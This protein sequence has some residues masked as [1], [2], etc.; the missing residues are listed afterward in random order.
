[1]GREIIKRYG[2]PDE[3]GLQ[4]LGSSGKDVA[5]ATAKFVC[6]TLVASRGG[7]VAAL[8]AAELC[9]QGAGFLYGQFPYPSG[10]QGFLGFTPQRPAPP[11]R[12]EPT[13]PVSQPPSP[14]P[15]RQEPLPPVSQPPSPPT[16]Q[17][18]S[19]PT[20]QPPSP[21]PSSQGFVPPPPRQLYGR[22]DRDQGSFFADSFEGALRFAAF[23]ASG[24]GGN[25]GFVEG[26]NPAGGSGGTFKLPGGLPNPTEITDDILKAVL[27]NE[28]NAYW[29]ARR[30][31][32]ALQDFFGLG[33][34][35]IDKQKENIQ[36][37]FT[38]MFKFF[39]EVIPQF[40]V[41]DNH[42]LQFKSKGVKRELGQRP[43]IAA[44]AASFLPDASLLAKAGIGY[45]KSGPGVEQRLVNQFLAN[46]ANSGWT[47]DQTKAYWQA[48]VLG[49]KE[50]R[51]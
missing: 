33:Q 3:P 30:L 49:A 15:P 51:K 35:K 47:V 36:S 29:L 45:D 22:Y 46:A 5:V 23:V 18:P 32:E 21:P 8:A 13:P 44:L 2:M 10:R 37:F 50:V 20:G 34:T 42:A 48:I 17:P 43:E 4:P 7:R 24:G 39:D 25:P 38:A 41:N 14:P 19:P 28:I 12:Q 9:G 6:G 27:P 31:G 1:V 11:P 26:E 16:G 40:Q